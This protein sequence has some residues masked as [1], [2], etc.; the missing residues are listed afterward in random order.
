MRHWT[1]LV[2]RGELEASTVPASTVAAD[3]GVGAMDGGE[4]DIDFPIQQALREGV[5][6]VLVGWGMNPLLRSAATQLRCPSWEVL[7]SWEMASTSSRYTRVVKFCT[8]QVASVMMRDESDCAIWGGP[9][10]TR[11]GGH[12]CGAR[13]ACRWGG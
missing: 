9:H 6:E 11:K 7:E 10:P 12:R 3:L 8:A 1:P 5:A 2:E 13:W 4:E